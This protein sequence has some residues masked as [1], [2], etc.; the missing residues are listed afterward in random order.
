MTPRVGPLACGILEQSRSGA[1]VM[2]AKKIALKSREILAS[3]D[4]LRW[5]SKISVAW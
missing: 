5:E 3:K 1:K 4:R 2:V